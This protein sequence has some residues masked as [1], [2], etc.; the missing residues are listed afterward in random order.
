MRVW[1]YSP[2]S[3]CPHASFDRILSDHRAAQP[4]MI[5]QRDMRLLYSSRDNMSTSTPE[6]GEYMLS[7][8]GVRRAKW[9]IME[10]AC[11]SSGLPL[12]EVA[13][14]KIVPQE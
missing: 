8:A 1:I 2:R 6:P 9:V 4:V 5:H 10:V 14:L 7:Q 3:P 13:A 12:V 11:D